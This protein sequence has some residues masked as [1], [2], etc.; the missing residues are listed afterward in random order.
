MRFT[1]RL[2]PRFFLLLTSLM[3]VSALSWAT[4]F[5]YWDQAPRARNFAQILT[6]V[7]NLTRA[8]LVAAAPERRP[9]LLHEL[10]MHEGVLIF[11]V[12][13][14][15]SPPQAPVDVFLRD[16]LANLRL[17]LGSET[18]LA[19][20]RDGNPGIFVLVDIEGDGYWIG[21]PRER[22]DRSRSLQWLGWGILGA[23][24]ALLTAVWFVSRL[25]RPLD[26]LVIAA[27]SVGKGEHPPPLPE[28]GPEELATVAT[29]FNQMN[30][31]LERQNRERAFILAGISH[32]LR[33]P[34]TRLRMGI[35]MTDVD[36]ATRDGME[37]DIE[38]M[39]ITIGQFLDYARSNEP[40]PLENGDPA[41]LMNEIVDQYRRRGIPIGSR[42]DH[43]GS[44]AMHGATLRRALCNLIDNSVR[45]ATTDNQASQVELA[46]LGDDRSV[47][48][49]V[50]D[51]GPGIP[52]V[53]TERMLR[54]F[55]RLNDAR[56]NAKGA[57]L[58][59][60]IVNRVV[61]QHAGKFALLPREGGGLIARIT[62]PR[63]R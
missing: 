8:A 37:T 4:L 5:L 33:T 51:R 14:N 53:E 13:A 2:L 45:Y 47:V 31:D 21:F 7:I 39:D 11:P 24:I 10:S 20:E 44:I 30:V 22:F 27:K 3:V 18:Q 35:E 26:R 23:F 6:S 50:T 38:E 29:A 48:I 32:D 60:S 46:L 25:T 42:I 19:T 12:E 36:A 63:M 1:N 58:G 55:T 41:A 17:S 56:S 61:R 15:E 16:V 49:E 34:L 28:D 59:L 52:E 62:L 9:G 40:A 57:G 43:V 54:P